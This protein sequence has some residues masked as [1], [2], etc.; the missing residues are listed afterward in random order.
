MTDKGAPDEVPGLGLAEAIEGLRDGL[1][2]ARASGAGS[3]IQLPVS[4]MTV[5]LKVVAAKTTGGKAGFRV[6][7]VEVEL[8]GSADRSR[9]ETHT[10]TVVFGEPVD[11]QGLPVKVAQATDKAKG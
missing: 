6:P 3:D 5:E 11:R 9:E 4:S 2:A 10:V 7:L 1:L 8:G